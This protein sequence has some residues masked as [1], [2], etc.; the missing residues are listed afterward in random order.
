MEAN[1]GR[2]LDG[3]SPKLMSRGWGAFGTRQGRGENE[4]SEEQPTLW[5]PPPWASPACGHLHPSAA[6]GSAGLRR[7]P[8]GDEI[9][10]WSRFPASL[11]V[12]RHLVATLCTGAAGL[13]EA[14]GWGAPRGHLDPVWILQLPTGDPRTQA[15]RGRV[16]DPEAVELGRRHLTGREVLDRILRCSSH[17]RVG[18]CVSWCLRRH[19][20]QIWFKT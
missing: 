10:M 2:E 3:L 14:A 1:P 13:A 8:A 19:D 6:D 5:G 11:R 4:G 9:T 18:G 20:F 7:L 12:W 17:D 15:E 16:Q